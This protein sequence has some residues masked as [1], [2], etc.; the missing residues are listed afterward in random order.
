MLRGLA[1]KTFFQSLSKWFLAKVFDSNTTL[2]I[3]CKS[4]LKYLD[5]KKAAKVDFK[6]IRL[7]KKLKIVLV[8]SA[9]VFLKQ[10]VLLI[11]YLY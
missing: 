2:K 9:N 3:H 4:F 5:T 6:L 7:V 1:L 8:G 11:Y 10:K